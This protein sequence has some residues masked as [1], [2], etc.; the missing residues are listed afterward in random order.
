MPRALTSFRASKSVASYEACLAG[1]PKK[2]RIS[3]NNHKDQAKVA[4]FSKPTN[5]KVTQQEKEQKKTA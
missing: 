5:T 2:K 3:E 4:T 1:V